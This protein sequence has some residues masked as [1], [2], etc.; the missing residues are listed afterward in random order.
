MKQLESQIEA[1]D[2]YSILPDI[3]LPQK[4]NGV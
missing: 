2:N 1:I 4:L 3:N